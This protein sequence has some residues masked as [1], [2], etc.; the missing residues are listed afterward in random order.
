MNMSL[1]VCRPHTFRHNIFAASK[2]RTVD[3][4]GLDR[5]TAYIRCS[6][7]LRAAAAQGPDGE[8][9]IYIKKIILYLLCFVA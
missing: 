9:D 2:P 6:R 3:V 4:R 5:K 8:C 1:S 7:G